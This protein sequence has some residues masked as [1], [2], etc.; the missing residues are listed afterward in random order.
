MQW[1]TKEK[2]EKNE[3][4]RP[5]VRFTTSR[6]LRH[7]DALGVHRIKEITPEALDELIG[8]VV[9]SAIERRDGNRR[10]ES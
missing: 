9:G 1:V 5:T 6:I 10:I 3:I 4:K 2:T 7:F 8:G